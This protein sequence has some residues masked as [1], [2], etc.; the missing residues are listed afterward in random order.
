MRVINESW[1][2]RRVL[3]TGCTGLLGAWLTDWLAAQRADVVGLVRDSVPTSNFYRLG[4]AD[5]VTT[6]R[7]AVEDSELIARALN[8]Y[9]IE[10]IFHLAA[11]PIVS[12]ANADPVS[13]LTTNVAGTWS[14][15][16][17]ARRTRRVRAIVVASSDKAYGTQADLPYR[18]DA[19]LIG[20]HPYDVSK[21][22]A[23]LIA[24]MYWHTYKVPVAITRCGNF[25]GGGDLNFN[26]IVPG[27]IRSLIDGQ[28][29]I[30]RSDGTMKR[31]Y[32]HILDAVMAYTMLAER[33]LVGEVQGEAFNFSN[34]Q[35][36]TVLELVQ[37]ITALM[38]R[39]D[40][41]PVVLNEANNE[42]PHQ[43]LSA[44]L[45]RTRLGWTPRY[46]LD[47]GLRD[48]IA[49]YRAFFTDIDAGARPA[50]ARAAAGQRASV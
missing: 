1:H 37:M 7:G 32:F 39:Q 11:Q 50:P 6:V 26:R 23:D 49:W 3:V 14:L 20:R 40:L 24:Q 42:I 22:C 45:A 34:E 36:V 28:R 44:Q 30:I 5:R 41:E 27:T 2:R 13:T 8:E 15:L 38:G 46:S 31:D 21:S 16:E 33:L 35:P 18:E 43:Y 19:P 17:A 29:P 12:I 9:E 48:T 4:L 25:Y 47:E 10:V